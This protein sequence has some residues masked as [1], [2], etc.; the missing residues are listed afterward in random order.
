MSFDPAIALAIA[1]LNRS[2]REGFERMREGFTERRMHIRWLDRFTSAPPATCSIDNL[3]AVQA[4]YA[5]QLD[6]FKTIFVDD[7]N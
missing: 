2:M 4:S 6:N 7:S 5:H 1:N 3:D